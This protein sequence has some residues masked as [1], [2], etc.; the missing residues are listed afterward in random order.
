M[1]IILE[2]AKSTNKLKKM[3]LN[4]N[5]IKMIMNIF[6]LVVI[7]RSNNLS[8]LKKHCVINL[9]E[10]KK[11]CVIIRNNSIHKGTKLKENLN[12]LSG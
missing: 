7:L 10:L 12:V 11:H 5:E 8:E 2:D 4:T 1:K 6:L 3:K 9:S